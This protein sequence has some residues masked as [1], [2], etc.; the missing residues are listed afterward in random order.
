MDA[1]LDN[2]GTSLLALAIILMVYFLLVKPYFDDLAAQRAYLEARR[3]AAEERQIQRDWMQR[4]QFGLNA[5][6]RIRRS[7]YETLLEETINYLNK[8]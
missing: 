2:P 6:R 1:I 8:E 3:K 7:D 5:V 4:A